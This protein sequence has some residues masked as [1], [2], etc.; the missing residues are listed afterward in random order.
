MN[1]QDMINILQVPNYVPRPKPLAIPNA[2]LTDEPRLCLTINAEWAEHVLGVLQVLDQPDAW[3]GTDE[4]IDAAREAVNQMYVML[5]TE[6]EPI[7]Y[8][9]F[10]EIWHDTAIVTNGGGLVSLSLAPS[11]F[12]RLGQF[13]NLVTYQSS[14][15]DGDEFKQNI[16]LDAGDYTFNVLGGQNAIGGLLDWYLD[17]ETTPF[18]AGMDWYDASEQINI[19]KVDTVT[20]AVAG[21][22]VL[23]G[24]VNGHNP[25]SGAYFIPLVKYWFSYLD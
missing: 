24:V 16:V 2:A 25:S 18:S 13:Y 23:R 20:I 15:A 1:S 4:E 8:P 14:Y 12:N 17:D 3:L 9:R 22:H 11:P 5:M 7:M 6:C 21:R 19:K 10:A